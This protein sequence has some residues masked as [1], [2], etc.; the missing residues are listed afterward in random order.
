MS[1]DEHALASDDK[2]NKVIHNSSTVFYN[3][4]N[5][6][7]GLLQPH[8]VQQSINILAEFCLI[9]GKITVYSAKIASRYLTLCII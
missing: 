3:R 2:A 9:H 4:H 8:I 1:E 5:R 6:Q 7:A